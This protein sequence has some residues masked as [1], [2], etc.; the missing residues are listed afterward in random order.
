MFQRFLQH[1]C[2]SVLL[3]FIYAF[4]FFLVS[5]ISFIFVLVLISLSKF[6][7]F[8]VRALYYT[9]NVKHQQMHEEFFRQL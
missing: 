9:K 3:Y 6:N 8:H 5:F 4:V 2:P 1:H 7:V